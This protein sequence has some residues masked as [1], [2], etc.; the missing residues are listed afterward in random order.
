MLQVTPDLYLHILL[1]HFTFRGLIWGRVAISNGNY[2]Q[3]D[4]SIIRQTRQ[5]AFVLIFS[6]K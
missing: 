1:R 6:L 4:V 5:E 3:L 2:L